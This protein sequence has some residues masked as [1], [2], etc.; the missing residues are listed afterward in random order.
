MAPPVSDTESAN[1]ANCRLAERA[2]GAAEASFEVRAKN[3]FLTYSKCLLDPQE[4]LRDITHKLRKFEPTYVYV[5]RE[6]HQDGT[7]HLHCFVQCKKHV[8]T[9]RAR[10]FDLEE[11]HPN[12]QNARMPHKVLAY[13]KKSPVSY[14]E[15][16]AYTERDVRKRKIDASTTKDA[17]MADI[18]RSSKSKEE[19]LSMVRKTFPFDWATRLQNFEYSAERLF[20]STPPPYVSPF[21]MPSQEEHP[22]LGAWLRA[23]LY[24]QG[25]NPAE[26]RKSLYICGPSRTGKTSWARSL[27]KHNYWQHS[28]DFLNI[29][30]DA[31]YNVIDDIP[32]KFV[33]CWKGL[34]GA[35]R[36][37]TVN[38]KYGKKRL[39]SNG[40][41]CIILANEDEDWLQQMQPGQADWFNANCEVHYMY[42][43]E[44]FFKSLGAATA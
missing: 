37:I 35:Q 28:V 16:G 38:P 27:G 31:E 20:P 4:A 13:C 43:G 5:A 24:T 25:R 3:I 40:V 2:P 32:F 14:A 12:V 30:P 8:R 26:R 36:D 1:S 17:K 9:T 22:V 18:I 34:V 41:P 19:Y 6:L 39:L 7:F 44:T 11:Y 42:Q 33:P 23:E 21:N 29:I 10:F 15:E